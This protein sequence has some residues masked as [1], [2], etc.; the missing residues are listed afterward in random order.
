M[1]KKQSMMVTVKN[2]V[3]KEKR[4]YYD[5]IPSEAVTEAFFHDRDKNKARDQNRLYVA[6]Y[7]TLEWGL[8][9][10]RMG[11]WCALTDT[12]IVK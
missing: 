9:T 7:S 6:N 12:S 8:K 11:N 1:T 3:T 4:I 10:V 2:S 5:L